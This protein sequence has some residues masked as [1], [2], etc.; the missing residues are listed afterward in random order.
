MSMKAIS[1]KALN[2]EIDDQHLVLVEEDSV[3]YDAGEST[4]DFPKTAKAVSETF[5]EVASPTLS[6]TTMLDADAAGLDAAGVRDADNNIVRSGSRKGLS[7]SV[8]YLDG[9]SGTVESELNIAD[10]TVEWEGI[11]GQNPPTMDFT[12]HFNEPGVYDDDPG[13]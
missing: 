5:H 10:V 2:V 8:E 6:F 9:E 7:A 1:G 4:N 11:D 13:A 12:L 3:D